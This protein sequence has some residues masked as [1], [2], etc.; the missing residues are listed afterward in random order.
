[1]F[2]YEAIFSNGSSNIIEVKTG[3]VSWEFGKIFFFTQKKRP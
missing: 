3:P 1:M 2:L